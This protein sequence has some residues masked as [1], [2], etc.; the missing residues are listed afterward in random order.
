VSETEGTP[1]E[2]EPSMRSPSTRVEGWVAA[3]LLWFALVWLVMPTV[4]Q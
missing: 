2:M 3:A 1:L 4:E